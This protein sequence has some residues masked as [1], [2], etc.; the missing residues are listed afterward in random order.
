MHWQYQRYIEGDGC[1]FLHPCLQMSKI[2]FLA[3]TLVVVVALVDFLLCHH[4]TQYSRTKKSPT[5]KGD[6]K[7]VL[8]N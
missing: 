4:V 7:K 5:P 8:S 2:P 1:M 3:V 6:S